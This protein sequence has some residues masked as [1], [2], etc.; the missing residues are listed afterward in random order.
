MFRE[1]FPKNQACAY[2]G[3]LYHIQCF[4]ELYMKL[5]RIDCPL[6]EGVLVREDPGIMKSDVCSISMVILA[7]D[8]SKMLRSLQHSQPSDADAGNSLDHCRK[9]KLLVHLSPALHQ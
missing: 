4:H 8:V 5:Q 9:M 6:K 2:T 1:T 3:Y 7:W